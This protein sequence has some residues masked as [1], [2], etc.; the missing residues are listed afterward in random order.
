MDFGRF[1]ARCFLPFFSRQLLMPPT[2][3]NTMRSTLLKHLLCRLSVHGKKPL[4]RAFTRY[5]LPRPSHG[6]L[7]CLPPNYLMLYIYILH[8]YV[9]YLKYC[10]IAGAQAH[11]SSSVDQH[12]TSCNI[13]NV[14]NIVNFILV[15]IT[16]FAALKSKINDFISSTKK[17]M[18]WTVVK[19]NFVS[20]EWS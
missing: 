14:R 6:L 20:H 9:S 5:S 10:R 8:L 16:Y 19:G 15:V 4:D 3:P 12:K 2:F 11:Y 17:K 13:Q 1:S 7:L 18:H